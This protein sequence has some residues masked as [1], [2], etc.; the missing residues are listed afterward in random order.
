MRCSCETV[1]NGQEL[2]QSFNNVGANG[3]RLQALW[4]FPPPYR[5]KLDLSPIS[6]FFRASSN[7]MQIE[8]NPLLKPLST[9]SLCCIPHPL[10]LEKLF[11]WPYESPC[12]SPGLELHHST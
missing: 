9:P 10:L 5:T 12:L 4:T 6:L 2:T 7:V 3:S 8:I 1:L 11:L